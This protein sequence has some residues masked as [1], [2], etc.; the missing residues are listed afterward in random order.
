MTV[1]FPN[2]LGWPGQRAAEVK[3]WFHMQI[4]GHHNGVHIQCFSI[5]RAVC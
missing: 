2:K 1:R 5:E 4:S 3:G